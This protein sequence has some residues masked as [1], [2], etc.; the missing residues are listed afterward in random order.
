MAPGIGGKR[1]VECALRVPGLRVPGKRLC[2]PSLHPISLPPG[3][4]RQSNTSPEIPSKKV[5][6]SG[7]VTSPSSSLWLDGD[8]SG[9]E[10]T[11][12]SK[13]ESWGQSGLTQWGKGRSSDRVWGF[14]PLLRCPLPCLDPHPFCLS[15]WT[16]SPA[17]A[18]TR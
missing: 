13:G 14:V 3:S 8:S 2:N 10:D 15:C 12:R 7:S 5:K 4:R 9:S 18:G 11:M 17:W 16:E 6:W 1:V